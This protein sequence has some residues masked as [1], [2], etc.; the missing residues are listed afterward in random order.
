MGVISFNALNIQYRRVTWVKKSCLP[1]RFAK[2]SSSASAS[3]TS[4]CE[5]KMRQYSWKN[6]VI[7]EW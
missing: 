3:N 2:F 6:T 5:D 7:A 1:E 4:D